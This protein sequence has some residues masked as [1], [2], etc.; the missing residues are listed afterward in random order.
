MEFNNYLKGFSGFN[1]SQAINEMA[2]ELTKLGVPKDLMQFI[3]KLSGQIH[4]MSQRGDE[5][6]DPGTGRTT[7]RFHTLKEPRKAKGGPWPERED[8]PMSHDVEV[9]GNKQGKK[10]IY[11]YLTQLLDSRK[12]T[13]IR[14]VLVNPTE[15]I[16]QYM[17]RKT[18]KMSKIQLADV[19]IYDEPRGRSATDQARMQGTSNK[20]G[21]YMRVVALDGDSGEPISAWE[22]TI[23]QMAEDWDESTIL[24]IME[25]EDRVRAKRKTR[26]DIKT[27]TEEQ[28]LKYFM[29]NFDK[30]ANKA[31]GKKGAE[32]EAK[33]REEFAKLDPISDYDGALI[34]DTDQGKIVKDLRTQLNK[35]SFDPESLE[36]KL[37]NFLELAFKEGEYEPMSS[38]WRDRDKANLSQMVKLHTIEQVASMFL[39]FLVRGKVHKTFYTDDPYKEL[40]IEDLLFGED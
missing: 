1:N 18:G 6:K 14:L 30:L 21:L 5:Q 7:D 15:D 36:P 19:G 39:H 3:H 16:V 17:T 40:G 28:F 35:G 2:S 32:A 13:G 31:I 10:N 29:D 33:Y 12:D 24:Y 4:K 11:H 22:G 23:G 8:I 25:D 27:V 20:R 9:R 34:A 26:T 37:N 38:E